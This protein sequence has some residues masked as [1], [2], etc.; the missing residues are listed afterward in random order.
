MMSVKKMIDLYVEYGL[1]ETTWDMLREMSYHGL[2][3]RENWVKFFET[4]KGWY[5]NEE[6]NTIDDSETEKTVYAY[7]DN[8]NLHKIA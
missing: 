5:F 8:G 4:C 1:D 2:I 3:S 6:T 7:D